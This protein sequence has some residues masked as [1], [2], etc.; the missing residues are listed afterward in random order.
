MQQVTMSGSKHFV[1]FVNDFTR[2]CWVFFVK[3]NSE[4]LQY[5]RNFKAQAKRESGCNLKTLKTDCGGEFLSQSFKTF[6]EDEGIHQE[7]TPPY[8]PQMNGV[9][10]RKNRITIEMA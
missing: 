4:A 7:L 1:L 3:E 8:T 9:V 2:M 5:F 6:S 10:E